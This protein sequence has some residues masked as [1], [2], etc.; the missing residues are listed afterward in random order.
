VALREVSLNPTIA[1]QE[2][3]EIENDEEI[4]RFKCPETGYLLWPLIRNAFI[5]FVMS[6][7]LYDTPL[8]S[9]Q[10]TPR[11][12]SAYLSVLKA[13]AHNSMR[14]RDIKGPILISSTGSHVLRN[15]R[16][17][18]RLS[19]HFALSA[20]DKTVTLESLFIDWHWPF[21][22]HSERVLFDAPILGISSLCGKFFVKKKHREAAGVL[23]E[24][25]A[26]RAQN[27]LGWSL[28]EQ[29]RELATK[30]LAEHIA[31]LPVRK[32]LYS[33]LFQRT[34]ARILIRQVACYG[35]DSSLMNVIA[36]DRG[37][38]T[39]EYQHGSISAGHDAYNFAEALCVS[40]EYKKT[41][42]QYFL[43]YGKWWTDQINAPVV[44]LD[45]GNP[46]RTESLKNS[47]NPDREKKDLIVLGD[48]IETEK[49]LSVC[50]SLAKGLGAKYR[51]VF[52]P[53]PLERERV[54]RTYGRNKGAVVIEWDKGIL[55]AFDTADTVVSEISTGLFEA[56]GLAKR[57]FLWDTPKARFA[58]PNHPFAIF[59]DAKDLVVKI[60]NGESGRIDS[61]TVEEFWAPNWKQ[62][63]LAFLQSVCPGILDS[64][65]T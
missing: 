2:I 27:L 24:F 19:D 4:L 41:L 26:R 31:S 11:P 45:I 48:G 46:D 53:H 37:I 7:M 9:D 29:R 23:V 36:R 39:A 65:G 16:Y 52:R 18:N 62:N 64:L 55:E 40:E 17:F 6:D 42:P 57:I 20:Q 51:I 25:V 15:G 33:R 5:R 63:Y 8:L 3:L 13:F 44:K 1:L 22:R 38:I 12:Q 28:P 34:G 32:R 21:P 59:S 58:Y 60:Q 30:R 47:V 50:S 61:S 35:G 10:R 43:G 56:I 14:G 49:Y 54:L